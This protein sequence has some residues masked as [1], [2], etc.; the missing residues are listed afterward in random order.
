[1]EELMKLHKAAILPF[2]FIPLL[3]RANYF[4][5]AWISAPMDRWDPAFWIIAVISG[6]LCFK[7]A[8]KLAAKTDWF[9]IF[10]ILAGI[11]MMGLG[12]AKNIN[13][14]YI[15]GSLLFI[16]SWIWLLWGWKTFFYC[17]PVFFI[18]A[19][20][21]P[22]TTY[23]A[24]FVLRSAA[25]FGFSAGLLVKIILMLAAVT[26][27]LLSSKW[28]KMILPRQVTIF[29]LAL[30][31]L[32]VI[33]FINAKPVS[34]G[35]PLMLDISRKQCGDWL[36]RPQALTYIEKRFYSGSTAERITYFDDNTYVSVLYLKIG[37]DV[38]QIHPAALCLKSDNWI[39][40]EIVPK[41][42][43]IKHGSASVS[44]I[45]TEYSGKKFML[46]VWYTSNR[47]ST[48]S[49][50]LFRKSWSEKKHWYSFQVI[51]PWA[52]SKAAAQKR[53][54]TFIR[55]FSSN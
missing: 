13:A 24:G 38:H 43:K 16:A 8:S 34:R 44:Q 15:A 11:A 42:I 6:I 53:L 26:W 39:I 21:C 19:L 5:A 7:T 55:D 4:I 25:G 23:W 49:F 29:L 2:V 22:S 3:F 41:K 37:D 10:A 35:T 30:F 32:A 40:H 46:Y 27:L 48:G 50:T 12:L 1:M 20:G 17:L 28:Q 45:T 51:T 47:F 36:G 31:A 33:L 54:D 18:A 14:V 9:G 52:P